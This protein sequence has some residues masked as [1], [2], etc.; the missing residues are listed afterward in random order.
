MHL[1]RVLT[2]TLRFL[3]SSLGLEQGDAT[4]DWREVWA[5]GCRTSAQIETLNSL[6]RKAWRAYDKHD[7]TV[8]KFPNVH[9]RS[10][11]LPLVYSC[12]AKVH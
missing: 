2:S 12:E 1:M 9:G 7:K 6:V 11:A 3:N 5:G 10:E 8:L 4:H